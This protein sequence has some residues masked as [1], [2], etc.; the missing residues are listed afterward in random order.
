MM[1][2]EYGKMDSEGQ[3]FY[4]RNFTTQRGFTFR[5]VRLR[6]KT[7]GELNEKRDNVMVIAHALTGNADVAG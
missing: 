3:S 6:Y 1:K 2:D 4:K 5:E 7:W